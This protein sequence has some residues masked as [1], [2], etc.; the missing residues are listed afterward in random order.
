VDGFAAS[1]LASSIVT[2]IDCSFKVTKLARNI[3]KAHGGL[4]K[5]LRDCH[6]RA[7]AL[8]LWITQFQRMRLDSNQLDRQERVGLSDA[9]LMHVI[10]QCATQCL[11]LSGILETLLPVSASTGN[12]IS[13]S[14]TTAYRSALRAMRKGGRIKNIQ[15]HLELLKKEICNCRL[16]EGPCKCRRKLGI[17]SPNIPWPYLKP[18]SR[19]TG[20]RLLDDSQQKHL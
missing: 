14:W 5:D 13:S 6:D 7:E 4:P 9:A 2:F 15:D 8:R 20:R 19:N 18:F 1:G 17:C 3:H 16:V 12:D 11:L 10:E